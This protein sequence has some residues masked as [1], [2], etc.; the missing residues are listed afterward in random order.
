[1]QSSLITL[2]GLIATTVMAVPSYHV[3]TPYKAPHTLKP[4]A[5]RSTSSASQ[6]WT[7]LLVS[8]KPIPIS[9]EPRLIVAARFA[10]IAATRVPTSAHNF[11]AICAAGGQRARCCVVPVADQAI[12]CDTPVGL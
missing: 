4:S 5:A 7:A 10:S 2:F 11:E 12:L 8:H 6:T 1:M 3:S 9:S